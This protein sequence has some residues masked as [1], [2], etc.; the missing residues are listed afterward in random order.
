MAQAL[1]DFEA[2]SAAGREVVHYHLED[3]TT[4]YTEALERV[5]RSFK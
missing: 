5:L 4:D 1:G 3:P 2:L